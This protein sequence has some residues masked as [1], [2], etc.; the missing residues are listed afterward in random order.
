MLVDIDAE[1]YKL[2]EKNE[3]RDLKTMTLR[4]VT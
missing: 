4:N 3:T 1:L 2:V